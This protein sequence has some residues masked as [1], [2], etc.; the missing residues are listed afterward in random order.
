MKIA[1]RA[2]AVSSAIVVAPARQT[3]RSA[4]FISRSMSKRN[5]FDAGL[6]P[7]TPVGVA[8]GFQIALS[9][10]MRDFQPAGRVLPAAALPPP[11]PC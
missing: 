2:D 1:G 4:R 9:C 6:E 5:G 10:L 8:D 11:W 7:G 3:T